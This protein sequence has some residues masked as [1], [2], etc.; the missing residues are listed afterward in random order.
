VSFALNPNAFHS[1]SH[2]SRLLVAANHHRAPGNNSCSFASRLLSE[3]NEVI[4]CG[5]SRNEWLEGDQTKAIPRAL[6][7]ALPVL[8]NGSVVEL[9]CNAKHIVDELS[10][11]PED[12]KVRRYLKADGK[13]LLKDHAALRQIDKIVKEKGLLLSARFPA[14]YEELCLA[15]EL[16]E[17]IRS[18]PVVSPFGRAA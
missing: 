14:T 15:D 2:L 10:R 8:P 11:P 4:G 13:T 12:R 17:E 6:I 1:G 5:S 18:Y 7:E 3:D 16:L 9:L